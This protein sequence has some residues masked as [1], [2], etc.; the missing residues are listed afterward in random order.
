MLNLPQVQ[1][2]LHASENG[3][4]CLSRYAEQKIRSLHLMLDRYIAAGEAA[5]T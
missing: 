3:Q 1:A 2:G 5:E 4:V